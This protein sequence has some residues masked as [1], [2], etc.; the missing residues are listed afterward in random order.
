MTSAF[1]ERFFS[2][3]AADWAWIIVNDD[4]ASSAVAQASAAAMGLC[5][6]EIFIGVDDNKQGKSPE[7]ASA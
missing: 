3:C 2:G 5:G 4:N 1:M 6:C 7:A